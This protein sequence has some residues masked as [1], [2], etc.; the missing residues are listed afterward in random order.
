M[1]IHKPKPWRGVREFL[2][3]YV[4]IVVGVLTALAG[5]QAVEWL[6][7]RHIAQEAREDI[8]ADHRRTLVAIGVTDASGACVARR[9][10]ELRTILDKAE[11]DGRLPPLAPFS[12]APHGPWALRGWE[13]VINGQALP[14]L[15]R[16]EASLYAAIASYI[17]K[18]K[19]LRDDSQRDWSVVQTMIGPSR[20]LSS[21]EAASLRAALGRVQLDDGAVRGNADTLA[22][23]IL[24]AG[25]LTPAEVKTWWQQ[26]VDMFPKLNAVCV[27]LGR[28]APSG[29]T[30]VLGAP[31]TPPLSAAHDSA[32]DTR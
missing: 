31:P 5:E 11:A 26:G 18:I 10:G 24:A 7:W 28:D 27:P 22:S 21:A 4:I 9:I 29:S 32:Y 20:P 16:G 25:L 1:D 13:G 14:H 19:V 15:R 8:A 6:H 30:V 17:D 12:T 3:E 23:M 2:K